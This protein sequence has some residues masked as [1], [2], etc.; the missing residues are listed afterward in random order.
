M[1]EQAPSDQSWFTLLDREYY[2]SEEVFEREAQAIFLR[3]W[4]YV[5]HVS[6]VAAAGDFVVVDLLGESVIISRGR[7][8]SINALLNS[9]RHRGFPVCREK[10]GNARLLVCGYH[11]WA[12]GLD[13]ALRKA[14]SID[15]AVINY[16]NWGLHRVRVE[17]WQGLIFICL[18]EPRTADLAGE[19]DAVAADMI[20]LD[21]TRMK[22]IHEQSVDL[23]TNWKVMRENFQECY[24]C[25]GNHPE[26]SLSL[27]VEATYHNTGDVQRKAEFYGGGS[28]PRPGMRSISMDGEAKC[29]K[30]LG[31]F[32]EPGA[33][34]PEQF[35]AGFA[36][37]PLFSRGLFS[38]DYG[39]IFTMNPISPGKV[40]WT[41]RWFVHEDAVEG[42]DYDRD[43]VTKLWRVS[44][45]EDIDLVTRSYEGMNSRRYVPGPLSASREPTLR[46]SQALYLDMMDE[47]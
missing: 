33:E 30:Y 6:E 40:R 39:V 7:D 20:Q 47:V 32:G 46:V 35:H 21:P 13:G 12:Y 18:G 2:F 44:V 36:I 42:T 3:Q 22:K 24:H 45:E 19:L 8:G 14:P 31:A 38:V 10:A 17:V 26:L 28:Q 4:H 5:A 29:S 16:D 1:N 23:E 15:D 25:A 11:N 37:H 43:E 9:C 27:D 41:S 34:I